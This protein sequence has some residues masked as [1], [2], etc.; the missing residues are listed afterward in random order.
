MAYKGDNVERN[1]TEKSG[2]EVTQPIRGIMSNGT[3]SHYLPKQKKADVSS[4]ACRGHGERS[5]LGITRPI[6]GRMTNGM[7][8]PYLPKQKKAD[9]SSQSRRGHTGKGQL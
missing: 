1:A 3:Q 4:Q 2:L 6:R 9:A 5:S 7:Q 8:S